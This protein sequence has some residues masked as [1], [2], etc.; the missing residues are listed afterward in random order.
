MAGSGM[1]GGGAALGLPP[2]GRGLVGQLRATRNLTEL[3]KYTAGLYH[4]LEAETGLAR[5]QAGQ[6]RDHASTS[7]AAMPRPLTVTASSWMRLCCI[8]S[9]TTAGTPPAR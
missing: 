6:L 8:N 3:A 2:V 9:R 5:V 7:P 4:S 1:P